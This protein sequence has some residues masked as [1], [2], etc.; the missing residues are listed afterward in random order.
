MSDRED[1]FSVILEDEHEVQWLT[2]NL[3]GLTWKSG[4][5]T[6]KDALN[7]MKE[8]LVDATHI[9]AKGLKKSKFLETILKIPVSNLEAVGCPKLKELPFRSEYIKCKLEILHR[10]KYN[11]FNE[12]PEFACALTQALKLA[13]WYRKTF[14]EGKKEK[15]DSL[16]HEKEEEE[17]TGDDSKEECEESG[18]QSSTFPYCCEK[19]CFSR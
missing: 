19:K 11:I 2:R 7:E 3:H 10:L 9:W 17:E 16:T 5:V 1:F 18:S 15:D 14:I 4:N 8:I 6:F 12:E 13:R